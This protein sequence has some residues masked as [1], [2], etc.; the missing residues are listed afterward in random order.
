MGEKMKNDTALANGLQAPQAVLDFRSQF[1][2]F[3]K[4]VHL[5]NNSKGALS[6]AVIAAHQEYLDSWLHEGAP[7]G[8]WVGK[9]EELRAAFAKMIGAGLHEVAVC[10]SA[11]MGLA[12]VVSCFDYRKRS[13]IAFDDFSFPSVTYLWHAQA[14][15]GA[16]I[17]RVHANDK[18]EIPVEAFDRV[19]DDRLQFLSVA[20]VCYKNGHRMDIPSLGR[21][22]R[23]V[24]AMF[25]VDDYQSSGSRPLNV[26]EAGVD[27]L[28][29]GTV[30]FLL[31]SAGVALLYVREGLLNELHPTITGWFGQE[32]PND[33]Q[34]ERH[35]EAKDA[36]RFQNGTPAIPSVYD[37][38]AG[39]RLV[40]TI[41]L[42]AIGDWID[43]LT[44]LL[45]TRLREEGFIPATP[46]DPA[47]RGPQVA[48]R[49]NDAERAVA[50][51]ARRHITAS[52]RDNNVRV[53]F[54]YYN[55]PGDIE[56]LI[57][58]FKEMKTLMPRQR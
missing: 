30:K 55:T 57:G 41:G 33:F 3:E 39:L 7:W 47:K 1:P 32:N 6:H 20:H 10:T 29:T 26:K 46:L 49:S 40:E 9:H 22:C 52:S 54:H 16:E 14:M 24:G 58:A 48:I 42:K 25:V 13:A 2:I 19:F 34:V 27:V 31:G 8:L 28:I 50:D 18:N 51:L 12:T 53:A 44:A 38:L 35:V 11:T 4:Q 15:R 43:S 45:M 23:D 17:R 5:A 56:A 37:S 21:K 36:T